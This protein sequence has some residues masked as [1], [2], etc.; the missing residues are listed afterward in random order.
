KES[1]SLFG[2]SKT[3]RDFSKKDSWGKNQFN[4]S[5]PASLCC[6][7]ASKDTDA[8]YLSIQNNKYDITTIEIKDVFG[9]PADSKDLYFAF[10]A[11]HTPFQK[12]VIGTLPR[13]DIVIQEESTGK[14][15]TGL[16][17]KLTAL[18]DNTT[19]A[20]EDSFYG[21]EIVVRPDT[22]VYLACSLA[23]SSKKL[24]QHLGEFKIDD[25]SDACQVLPHIKS[26]VTAIEKISLNIG[27]KQKPFLLQP[28]WKTTGKSPVLA[29]QCLDIFVWSDA[30]FSNFIS[31]I[32]NKNSNV[33][34]ITRQTRTAI[35]LYKML[36]DFIENGKFNHEE[37][38][39]NL[40][41]NTK[42]DKAF[43]SAGN[44]TNKYM[45]TKRLET[46]T[47]SK[48][49][50]KNI[51]LGGGQNMLSPERRFDAIIFNS[52]ELFK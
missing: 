3:N 7:L 2:L 16:E 41:Y 11:Q 13:T 33:S 38:I 26:I 32:A 43:A 15:L 1:P 28:I 14:C 37:I 40:S 18:P 17:V 31:K 5:F 10:E 51:I 42:N 48:S 50:I 22:I 34:K 30:G 27:E 29:D 21:S 47:I 39:D 19:C 36:K 44:V 35:W 23:L 6:Y 4:S 52:P 9:I 46:P 12:C 24:K 25:W 45:S 49:E 20:L 8:N